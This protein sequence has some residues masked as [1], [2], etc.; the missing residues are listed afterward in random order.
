MAIISKLDLLV[1]MYV[2]YRGPRISMEAEL[3]NN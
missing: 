3:S 1:N 2:R